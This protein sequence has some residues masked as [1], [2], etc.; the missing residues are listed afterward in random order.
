LAGKT[1]SHSGNGKQGTRRIGG[2]QVR[3]SGVLK[4]LKLDGPVINIGDVHAP[5]TNHKW[6]KWVYRRVRE[7]QPAYVVQGGD[8]YDFFALS[9]Y[10]KTLDVMTPEAEFSLGRRMAEDMWAEVKAAAPKARCIQKLGNHDARASKR[11]FEVVPALRGLVDLE[12]PFEFEGVET[13]H[14]DTAETWIGDVA[15]LHG[16]KKFGEHARHNQACTISNHLHKGGVIF[17]Q[18]R[19]GVYWELNAGFGADIDSVAMRYRHQKQIHGWTL[20]LG[21]VDEQGPRFSVFPGQ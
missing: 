21:E 11:I 12:A 17:F 16:Y 18:N 1:R 13:E 10:A 7:V 19:F 9:K 4:E 15:L 2:R 6:L 8:L 3:N 20:G 5:F 14:D